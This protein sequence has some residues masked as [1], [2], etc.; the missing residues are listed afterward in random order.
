MAL[1]A[2]TLIV[3]IP[4]FSAILNDPG[5][6]ELPT[7]IGPPEGPEVGITGITPVVTGTTV[8]VV[9]AIDGAEDGMTLADPLV[10]VNE[11]PPKGRLD[12]GIEPVIEV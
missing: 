9:G 4:A 8:F 2:L 11:A 5:L 6:K 3:T 7:V 1:G 12:V 10:G